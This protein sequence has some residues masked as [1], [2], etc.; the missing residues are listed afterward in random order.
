M[1]DWRAVP[2]WVIEDVDRGIALRRIG[3]DRDD[4]VQ[5]RYTDRRNHSEFWVSMFDETGARL[6]SAWRVDSRVLA[7]TAAIAWNAKFH[8]ELPGEELVAIKENV[9]AALAHYGRTQK[10][11]DLKIDFS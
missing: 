1:F 9:R 2:E 6:K 3:F 7:R 8:A 5:F 11:S 10:L 4:N